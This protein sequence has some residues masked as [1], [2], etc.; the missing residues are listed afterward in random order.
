[1]I[2]SNFLE[3]VFLGDLMSG[4]SFDKYTTYQG[5]G[6]RIRK[7]S[8]ENKDTSENNKRKNIG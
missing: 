6:I 7:L 2:D 3:L 4:T 8:K 5:R 1:M